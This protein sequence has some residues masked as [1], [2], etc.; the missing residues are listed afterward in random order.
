MKTNDG[1]VYRFYRGLLT[2]EILSIN[3]LEDNSQF[4]A[5]KFIIPNY[6]KYNALLCGSSF[7]HV[8][9]LNREMLVTD[10]KIL[11]L[12][13]DEQITVNII[14]NNKRIIRELVLFK[15]SFRHH[16]KWTGEDRLNLSLTCNGNKANN[17]NE[18]KTNNFVLR[19]QNNG[20]ISIVLRLLTNISGLFCGDIIELLN[21]L[22]Q[23]M[24]R[25]L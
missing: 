16:Y 22:I 4:E 5:N 3:S 20:S 24:N 7:P 11:K 8:V 9:K 1:S 21:L 19:I 18:Y 15:D 17:F 2:G 6:Y 25:N 13:Q 10:K 12:F 23:N 14:L